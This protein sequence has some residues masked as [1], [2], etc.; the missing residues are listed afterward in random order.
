M[1]TNKPNIIGT[2]WETLPDKTIFA[3]TSDGKGY[4]PIPKGELVL[5]TGTDPTN[6]FHLVQTLGVQAKIISSWWEEENNF[7]RLT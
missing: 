5:V 7:N 6:G 1:V 3:Y 4:T 2:L